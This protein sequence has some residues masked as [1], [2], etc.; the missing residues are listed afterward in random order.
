MRVKVIVADMDGT[1]LDNNSEYDRTRFM[2]QYCR[3]KE[4]GIRF[5]VA[6]GNQYYQLASFFPGIQ[7]EIAFVAENGA[8]VIDSGKEIFHGELKDGS[9]K[10]IN[11]ILESYGDINFVVCGLKSAWVKKGVSESFLQNMKK[12]YHR[13]KVVNSYDQIEDVIFKYALSLDD[14]AIPALLKDLSTQLEAIMTPVTSGHGSLDLI[15]PGIHKA[16]GIQRLLSRWD[17]GREE[18]V[19]FGDSGNDIEMLTFAKYSF[20]MPNATEAVKRV[21]TYTTA[22]NNNYGVLVMIDEILA[23]NSPFQ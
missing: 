14:K 6:S 22:D 20:A 3:M 21:S 13:L 16:S 10:K 19:A 4:Q 12:Y 2:N 11:H 15:I 23:G 9:A 5:V 18:V 7:D 17:V 1:F 8:L